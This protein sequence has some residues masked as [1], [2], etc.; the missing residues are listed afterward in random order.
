M[1]DSLQKH[2]RKFITIDDQ[3]LADALPFF[4]SITLNKKENLLVEGQVCK[5]NFFVVTGC[6]RMFFVNEKGVEQ[7]VQ[8]A[9]ENWWLSDYT[10]F[11][12]QKPA[13]FSIQAVEKSEVLAID[14]AQHEEMLSQHPS[15]ERYFRLVHQRAHAAAQY[16]MKYHY[17]HSREELYHE[18]AR[19]FPEFVQRIPQYLLA[20]YLGFTPEYLSEI[21]SRKHS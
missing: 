4:R 20:S 14:F 15:L 18:F 19:L 11:S 16:R 17:D 12:T 8:F 5:S 10:S 9:L 7:T 6:L 2:I 13:V 3:E 21:R 1:S